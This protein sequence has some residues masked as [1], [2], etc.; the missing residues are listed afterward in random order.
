MTTIIK[1]QFLIAVLFLLTLLAVD[2]ARA[3]AALVTGG[4]SCTVQVIEPPVGDLVPVGTAS[5]SFG[6][7][8]GMVGGPATTGF[9]RIGVGDGLE[10]KCM[11]MAEELSTV[12]NRNRCTTSAIQESTEVGGNFVSQNW[13]FSMVCSGANGQV[14]SNVSDLLKT[15]ISMQNI[16]TVAVQSTSE[17]ILQKHLEGASPN[18]D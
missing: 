12:A 1:N 11:T 14:V 9:V 3:Q 15:F 13:R 2:D 5:L 17:R 4:F 10:N 8:F 16:D 6:E 7:P 18:Q